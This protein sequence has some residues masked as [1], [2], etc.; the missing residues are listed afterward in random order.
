M[1]R[2]DAQENGLCWC[3]S[4]RAPCPPHIEGCGPGRN[5]LA[6]PSLACPACDW[7]AERMEANGG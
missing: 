3:N 4:L 5:M 7:L 1:C 2:R 6:Y